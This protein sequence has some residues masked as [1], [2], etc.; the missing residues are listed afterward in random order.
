MTEPV[1]NGG[2]PVETQVETPVETVVETPTDGNV[3][4]P[5][6]ETNNEA[7]VEN[8]GISIPDNFKEK[9]WASKIVGENGDVDQEKLFKLIDGQDYMIG[10]KSINTPD[11]N[12]V[13]DNDYDEYSKNLIPESYDRD[14]SW[15]DKTYDKYQDIFKHAGLNKVAANRLVSKFQ[16]MSKAEREEQ[17]G[18]DSYNQAM[19]EKFKTETSRTEAEGKVRGFLTQYGSDDLMKAMQEHMPSKALAELTGAMDKFFNDYGAT[20]FSKVGKPNGSIQMESSEVIFSRLQKN[21]YN[22]PAERKADIDK[23]QAS[24]LAENNKK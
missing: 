11:F 22:N 9:G 4:T 18:D 12:S 8:Q 10:K 1:E 23:H 15:D 5:P 13:E 20:T 7:L 14:E 17:Y 6:I 24:I 2:T 19:A 3:D 16:E 21:N